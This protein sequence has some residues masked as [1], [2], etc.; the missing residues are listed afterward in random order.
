[1]QFIN[2]ENETVIFRQGDPPV[3]CYVIADGNVGVYVAQGEEDRTPRRHKRFPSFEGWSSYNR[4]SRL[5]NHVATLNPGDV[6]GELALVNNQKRAAC[7]KCKADCKLMLIQ[8][9]DFDSVCKSYF[10]RQ[11]GAKMQFLMKTIP[12]L[13]DIPPPLPGAKQHISYHFQK[14]RFPFG[15]V[16]I[17]QGSSVPF[18]VYAV[19]RGSVALRRNATGGFVKNGFNKLSAE[20]AAAGLGGAESVEAKPWAIVSD[21]GLFGT[22]PWD[23]EEP[24]TVKVASDFCDVFTMPH[25]EMC[26]CSPNFLQ[27]LQETIVGLAA[28]RMKANH[29]SYQADDRGRLV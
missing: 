21:G 26:H 20:R 18:A 27:I 2:V 25:D 24:F 12:G 7:L 3:N 11:G 23:G 22:V 6:F 13:S 1:V 28:S 15:H 8:R 17:T 16:F 29:V 4:E 5:G 10:V 19:Y 14:E 9:P